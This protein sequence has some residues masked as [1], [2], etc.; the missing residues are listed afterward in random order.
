MDDL[1]DEQKEALLTLFKLKFTEQERMTRVEIKK[2]QKHLEKA[3]HVEVNGIHLG[4]FSE[5]E[6]N[7]Y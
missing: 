1:I 7:A 5:E 2:L 6:K 4:K 3:I